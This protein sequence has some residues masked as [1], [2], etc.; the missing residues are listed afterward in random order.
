MEIGQ[1]GQFG[2]TVARPVEMDV[3]HKTE[4]APTLVQNTMVRIVLGNVMKQF[5]ATQIH[6]QLVIYLVSNNLSKCIRIFKS[7]LIYS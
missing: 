1:T 7:D 4:P 3:K 2:Q 5:L 6:A